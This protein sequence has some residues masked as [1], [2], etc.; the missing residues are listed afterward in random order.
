MANYPIS[1][2]V[3][4]GNEGQWTKTEEGWI[5]DGPAR[6]RVEDHSHVLDG[7]R[8]CYVFA[9]F[10]LEDDG[11]SGPAREAEVEPMKETVC[12]VGH[13]AASSLELVG[14]RGPTDTSSS[15]GS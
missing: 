9:G 12:P 7:F 6:V 13:S 5:W 4:T 2:V 11:F 10:A 8:T 15:V 14:G 1:V 3:T